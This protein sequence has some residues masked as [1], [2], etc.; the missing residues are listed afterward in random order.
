MIF[1]DTHVHLDLLKYRQDAIRNLK[2][3]KVYSIAV[4]NLPTI[5]HHNKITIP[6]SKYIKHALGY[7]PELVQ[8]Y[9][10]LL[11]VFKKELKRTRYIGEIG[12]DGSSRNRESVELQE[13]IF[14]SIVSLCNEVGGKI[15]TVHCRQAEKK[16]LNILGNNFNGKVILHWYSGNISNLEIAIKKGYWFSINPSMLNSQKGK[17]IIKKIP[18]NKLLV[19]TDSPFGVDEN[20]LNYGFIYKRIIEGVAT[21]KEINSLDTKTALDDNFRKLLN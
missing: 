5:F 11:P 1:H 13:K 20:K 4:T 15:L 2:S 21:I 18:L 7:H 16:T 19:E 17:E 14:S 12:I 10:D 8:E 6:E 9:P 3:N